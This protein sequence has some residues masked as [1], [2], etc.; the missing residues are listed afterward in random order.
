MMN[1]LDHGRPNRSYRCA[2]IIALLAGL[3]ACQSR[4]ETGT[5]AT[6]TPAAA[7]RDTGTVA[8]SG[9]EGMN[10]L[11]LSRAG[12]P[13]V[14][15]IGDL[16][17]EL[18][19]LTGATITVAGAPGTGVPGTTIDVS[20]YEVLEVNGSRA[21]SGVLVLRDGAWA[22]D[23]PDSFVRLDAVPAALTN[24]INSKI[25]VT[26]VMENGRVRVQSFGIIR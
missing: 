21:W 24:R 15:L 14:G 6:A 13:D 7:V 26:G 25:W 19:T 5:A 2:G 23:R 8:A 22:L 11:S 3:V 16:L 10:T 1:R 17:P 4:G 18:R 12:R 20:S 9:V